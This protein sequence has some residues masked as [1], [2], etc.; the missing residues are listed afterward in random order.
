M[1][2][3]FNLTNNREL[4]EAIENLECQI[5][6]LKE[7]K[8]RLEEKNLDIDKKI[9]QLKSDKSIYRSNFKWAYRDIKTN[10]AKWHEK[11][12]KNKIRI[13]YTGKTGAFWNREINEL[14]DLKESLLRELKV[15]FQE[16]KF[17]FIESND[18]KI[19]T[20][21]NTSK[22]KIFD[23]L[24]KNNIIEIMSPYYEAIK[25][26][27][28]VYPHIKEKL[29]NME[30]A[31]LSYAKKISDIEVLLMQLNIG[32]QVLKLA[33]EKLDN[34]SEEQIKEINNKM[35]HLILEYYAI[36][37]AIVQNQR[38]TN[39]KVNLT[40]EYNQVDDLNL[41]ESSS[42]SHIMKPKK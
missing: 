39:K 18:E 8:E 21:Q 35:D 7:K 4:L 10:I 9:E 40:Y 36:K 19:Y 23:L 26:F 41:I 5:E 25:D 13:F 11:A 22:S 32:Q 1:Q 6:R 28:K 16:I 27:F 24:H 14:D 33:L 12:L 30:L 17:L 3:I 34:K 31:K 29:D 20:L 38:K 15:L 37:L 42:N 2:G